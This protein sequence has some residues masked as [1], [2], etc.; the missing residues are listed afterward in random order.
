MSFP[1]IPTGGFRR[2]TGLAFMI[3]WTM[4]FSSGFLAASLLA[5]M[6]ISVVHDRAV[7]LTRRRL[8]DDIP[9]SLVE[10]QADKDRLRADFAISTRRLEMSVEQ[11]RVKG[12]TQL[13]EIG[14][15]A[16][17]INRLKSELARKI[18]VAYELAAKVETLTGKLEEAERERERNA[19]E[20]V[21]TKR[22]LSAKDVELVQS[23]TEQR[24]VIDTQRIEIAT[25]KTQI[26]QYKS[27]VKNFN[28]KSRR[29]PT[30]LKI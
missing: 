11:L 26:E 14:R 29:K 3:E 8:E 21:S 13:S 19:I 27:Q 23:V 4:F 22:A 6:L 1:N 30:N 24:L 10:I 12:T 16:E 7:R 5:L 28:T 9:V 18:A 20:V 17:M 25:L 15:K 2:Q